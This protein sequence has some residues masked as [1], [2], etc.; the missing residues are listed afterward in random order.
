MKLM[1]KG[2]YLWQLP[3]CDQGDPVAIA[4]RAKAAGLSHAMIKIADGSTWPYNYDF[5]RDLDLIPPVR[6]SLREAGVSV[7]GWHYVR[8]DDP[9]N[10]AQLAI[11]RILELD[12]EGY[13]IDAEGEYRTKKKRAAASRF[14][15]EMRKALPDLTIALSTYRYPRSHRDFPFDEFMALCDLSMPQV[16]FEQMHNPEEQLERTVEQYMALTHARPVIPTAPTYARGDWRPSPHEI[17]RFFQKAQD[18]ELTAANAWSWDFATRHQYL[19]LWNA[20]AEFPWPVEPSVADMPERLLGRLNEGD[21][22]LVAGLY[23]KNAAHVTGDRTIVGRSAIQEWYRT[24]LSNILQNGKF[25][26]TGK[27]G[28]GR[29]RQFMWRAT[30]NSGKVLDGNDTLGLIDG[31]IQYHYTYFNVT[32]T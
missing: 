13:V 21:A 28:S 4:A 23:K 12:L 14:M 27:S 19:D 5:D 20:V 10:E 8:G 32:A 22:S 1:G 15:E 30:S 18:L 3:Y 25:E 6:K 17:H 29:T 26:V 2:Y 9:Y 11:K 16:Y 7:W 31:R 24:F